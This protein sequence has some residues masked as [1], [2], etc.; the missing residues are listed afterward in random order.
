MHAGKL[1][2]SLD[3]ICSVGPAVDQGG[4]SNGKVSG[5]G[6]GSRALSCLSKTQRSELAINGGKKVVPE[7]DQMDD[8][9][10][11]AD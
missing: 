3:E 5:K 2:D 1:Q 6:K 8:V 7:P 10:V 9:D 4:K 11:E